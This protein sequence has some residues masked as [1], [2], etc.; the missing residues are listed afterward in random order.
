[1]ELYTGEIMSQGSHS[2]TVDGDRVQKPALFL[3]LVVHLIFLSQI[4]A[5]L[6]HM[7]RECLQRRKQIFLFQVSHDFMTIGN[8]IEVMQRCV[9]KGLEIIL[10]SSG[11]DGVY[12]LIEIEIHKKIG[13]FLWF[14]S[15]TIFSPCKE[16]A[17]ECHGN[18]TFPAQKNLPS[19]ND[20]HTK[21]LIG[22]TSF[23]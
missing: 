16:D 23:S 22:P 12:H 6:L 2:I 17:V 9:K 20:A 5:H 1:M 21:R 18:D 8:R 15:P 19:G 10:L 13:H 7:F 3:V 14:C 11:H 4:F